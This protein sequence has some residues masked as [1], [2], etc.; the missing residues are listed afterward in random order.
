MKLRNW[1]SFVAL[2]LI[3]GSAFMW[4]KIVVREISPYMLV[5]V[6]LFFGVV[7]LGV[8]VW[9]KKPVLPRTPKVW[10][11][12]AVLGATNIAIPFLF[13]SWGE[14]Y[15][16]SAVTAILHSTVPLF[17]MLMAHFFLDDDRVTLPRAA[18]LFLGFLGVI[19]LMWHDLSRGVHANLLGEGAILLAALSYAGSAVL[20]RVK[21]RNVAH[22]V[23]AFFPMLWAELLMWGG[24]PLFNVPVVLPRLRLTWISVLWLGMVSS[25]FA[26]ILFFHLLHEIGPT[27]T[28]MI[29]Y[30]FP[31]VGLVLGAVFLNE[32]VSWNLFLGSVL[33]VSGIALVNKNVNGNGKIRDVQENG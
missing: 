17:T 1:L 12:L 32:T 26:Y 31:V 30:I 21:L 23:Q 22:L 18:G 20:I 8:Y 25:A 5:T 19:V 2:G 24:V 15:V 4:I 11:V 6:R 13:V 14:V 10:A 7:F 9:F 27:R 28:T 33:V 16:D 29:T 3:W